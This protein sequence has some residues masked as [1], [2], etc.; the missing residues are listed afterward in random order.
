MSGFRC[1]RRS[2]YITDLQPLYRSSCVGRHLQ[3]YPYFWAYPFFTCSFFPLFK[4]LVPCSR[5]IWLM[6]AF[7]AHI[8]WASPGLLY[9]IVSWC[10]YGNQNWHLHLKLGFSEST[11]HQNQGFS[12]VFDSFV[13]MEV[14][15]SCWLIL[16]CLCMTH[17]QLEMI[18]VW[19][20]TALLYLLLSSVGEL[21]RRLSTLIYLS[22]VTHGRGS[23]LD[24]QR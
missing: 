5:L 2:E 14:G 13:V 9:R 3:F 6:S 20:L 18:T 8:K 7:K 10:C 23:L 17:I 24:C 22:F 1:E 16:T 4:F 11:H 12:A 19:V 15:C 21:C